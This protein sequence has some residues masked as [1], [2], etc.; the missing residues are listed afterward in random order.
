MVTH[1]KKKFLRLNYEKYLKQC[2]LPY[3]FS[4]PF[5][6]ATADH[7]L[8]IATWCD[9]IKHLKWSYSINNGSTSCSW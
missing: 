9:T 4:S 1:T 8:F 2:K 5:L 7:V 3:T 6:C